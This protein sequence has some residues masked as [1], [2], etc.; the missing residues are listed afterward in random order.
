M[1]E[2]HLK[3]SPRQMSILV[4]ALQVAVYLKDAIEE[5]AERT[6]DSSLL[7]SLPTIEIMAN[8]RA[9][10]ERRLTKGRWE[11]KT[12]YA[13]TLKSVRAAV[14]I[15]A[16]GHSINDADWGDVLWKDSAQRI[17]NEINDK[18]WR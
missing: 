16:I 11:R 5:D 17:I 2:V 14:M 3:L 15:S 9:V 8:M 7:M 1:R 13:I 6:R 12:E 4:C 10:L 18:L